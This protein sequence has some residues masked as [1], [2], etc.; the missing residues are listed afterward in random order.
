MQEEVTK[1]QTLGPWITLLYQFYTSFT[2]RPLRK[3]FFLIPYKCD[4]RPVAQLTNFNLLQIFLNLSTYEM[5][6]DVMD[7]QND[8]QTN[9]LTD[10]HWDI[11]SCAL[12]K[13]KVECLLAGTR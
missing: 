6:L 5:G 11:R 1:P 10:R 13:K 7:Q 8:Q 3:R 4:N 2:L 9:R 12:L